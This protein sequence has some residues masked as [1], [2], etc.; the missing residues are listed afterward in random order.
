VLLRRA[1]DRRRFLDMVR[2][3]TVFEDDG[4]RNEKK[5][6]AYRPTSRRRRR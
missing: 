4:G 5:I 1:F 2:F 6:A 3:F